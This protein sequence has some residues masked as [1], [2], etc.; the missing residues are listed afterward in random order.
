M[1]HY[2]FLIYIDYGE[3]W[4][5]TREGTFADEIPRREDFITAA[6]AVSKLDQSMTRNHITMNG[7]KE[8]WNSESLVDIVHPT[9]TTNIVFHSYFTK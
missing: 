9:H 8:C 1:S 5:D 2:H 6:S 4:L 3:E 7:K